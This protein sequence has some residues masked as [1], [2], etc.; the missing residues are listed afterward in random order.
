MG[1]RWALKNMFLRKHKPLSAY[2]ELG[3]PK[4]CIFKYGWIKGLRKGQN[5]LAP[6]FS[7]QLDTAY[8]LFEDRFFPCAK[9]A[10]GSIN[11][12]SSWYARGTHLFSFQYPFIM[13]RS[14]WLTHRLWTH[15]M[16]QS[17]WI[18]GWATRIER[19]MLCVSVLVVVRWGCKTP[20]LRGL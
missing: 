8:I 20:W 19:P 10:T 18:G 13:E 1:F 14:S 16:D 4:R 15:S 9:V 7:A 11:F 17:L 5:S 6:F 12:N 3:H 2:M